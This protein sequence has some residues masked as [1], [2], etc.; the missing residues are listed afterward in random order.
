MNKTPMTPF[1]SPVFK[2]GRLQ[3]GDEFPDFS[4]RKNLP[5]SVG[6]FHLSIFASLGG[7]QLV[8]SLRKPLGRP[9]VPGILLAVCIESESNGTTTRQSECDRLGKIGRLHFEILVSRPSI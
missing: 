7:S 9:K 1:S 4:R 6:L 5:P 8:W 2:A 3:I